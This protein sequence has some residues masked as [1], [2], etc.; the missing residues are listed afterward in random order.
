MAD[1]Q[2]ERPS[3]G[4]LRPDRITIWPVDDAQFGI[5]VLYRGR[6]GYQRAEAVEQELTASGVQTSFRQELD[7]AWG[8]RFGPVDRDAMLAV[9]NGTVW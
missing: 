7:G 6:G 5:D 2:V 8:V 1:V 3:I 4:A 9:L